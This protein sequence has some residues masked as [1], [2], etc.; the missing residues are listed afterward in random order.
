[1]LPSILPLAGDLGSVRFLLKQLEFNGERAARQQWNL[2]ADGSAGE[3][4]CGTVRV[5]VRWLFS[6]EVEPTEDEEAPLEEQLLPIP[7]ELS[8]TPT[9]RLPNGAS[10]FSPSAAVASLMGAS[11]GIVAAGGIAGQPRAKEGEYTLYVHVIEC[12]EMS[13]R[14][15]DNKLGDLSICV[16]CFGEEFSTK[17]VSDATSGVFDETFFLH[18]ERLTPAALNS[19][20]LLIRAY[21]V[22]TFLRD[23]LIGQNTISLSHIYFKQERRM[24]RRWFALADPKRAD[25]GVQGYV[26][27][28]IQLCGPDDPLLPMDEAAA[29]AE[30]GAEGGGAGAVIRPP[31]LKTSLHFLVVSFRRAKHL[32]RMDRSSDAPDAFCRVSFNNHN[33]Q[34]P[35]ITSRN[36]AWHYQFWLPIMFPAYG[37]RVLI[38]VHDQDAFNTHELIGEFN[39]AFGDDTEPGWRW[40][41]IYNQDSE[42]DAR[43][44]RLW[45]GSLL[46]N[47]EVKNAESLDLPPEP[48]YRELPPL[49][50]SDPPEEPYELRV[51]A[52]AGADLLP[53]KR[54]HVAVSWG[55]YN[56]RTEQAVDSDGESGQCAWLQELTRVDQFLRLTLPNLDADSE[57]PD[58]LI[59]LEE[60]GMGVGGMSYARRALLRISTAELIERS[61]APEWRLFDWVDAKWGRNRPVPKL[62]LSVAAAPSRRHKWE[63]ARVR[64]EAF[65]PQ[66]TLQPRRPL[67]LRLHLYAAR[68]LH[69]QQAGPFDYMPDAYVRLEYLGKSV[70]TPTIDDTMQPSYFR[71]LQLRAD[72]YENLEIAPDVVVSVWDKNLGDDTLLGVVR[73]R[74]AS[75]L[76]HTPDNPAIVQPP[77]NP[78][79]H[80]LYARGSNRLNQSHASTSRPEVL[81]QLE[82][83]PLSTANQ[84]LPPPPSLL[85]KLRPATIEIVALGVRGVQ[86]TA[87]LLPPNKPFMRFS[88]PASYAGT[89]PLAS[90]KR[91]AELPVHKRTV[92][93][94]PS[95]TPSPKSPNFLEVCQL[96]VLIP[97]PWNGL[98]A[99]SVRMELVDEWM[100]GLSEATLGKATLDIASLPCVAQ[101]GGRI[102]SELFECELYSTPVGSWLA[103][104]MSDVA[105]APPNWCNTRY[106]PQ[107]KQGV[108]LLGRGW[109]WE[110]EWECLVETEADDHGFVT[111]AHGW[112]YS[113]SFMN[114]TWTADCTTG[115]VRRRRWKRTQLANREGRRSPGGSSLVL[116]KLLSGGYGEESLASSVSA[117]SD[118]RHMPE[119]QRDRP[120]CQGDLESHLDEAGIVF[121]SFDMMHQGLL[122][123]S[124]VGTFK[125]IVRLLVKDQP[126]W[127]TLPAQLGDLLSPKKYEV[128]LYVLTASNLRPADSSGTSDPYVIVK[129]GDQTKGSRDTHLS[130]V[131]NAEFYSSFL[132]GAD[133]PG[134]SKLRVEVWDHDLFSSDDLIGATE[135]DLE[136]RA[137]SPDWRAFGHRTPVESRPLYGPLSRQPQGMLNM[138]IDIVGANKLGGEVEGEGG[139]S[140][141]KTDVK[142]AKPIQAAA[143]ASGG[144]LDSTAQPT[145]AVA[146][147]PYWDVSP[148]PA[149]DW[150]LRLVVWDTKDVVCQDLNTLDNMNDLY[151]IAQYADGAKQE[152]DTHWR[153][154]GGKAHF[155][156]RMLFPLTLNHNRSPHE[157]LRLQLWDRDVTN[158]DDCA[159]EITIDLRPWLNKCFW[160]RFANAS[161][162]DAPRQ[163]GAVKKEFKRGRA[164]VPK[165]ERYHFSEKDRRRVSTRR[166]A[167]K[168][169]LTGKLGGAVASIHG[170][171]ERPERSGT[172]DLNTRGDKDLEKLVEKIWLPVYMPGSGG[173]ER[174]PQGW[175]NISM[176]L[177]D[178][179]LAKNDPVGRGREAPNKQPFLGPPLGRV[180]LSLN[181]F[182]M[183]YQLLGPKL[184]MRVAVPMCCACCC[185]L[186]I[187]FAPVLIQLSAVSQYLED[188]GIAV[189]EPA[190][191]S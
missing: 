102:T 189:E 92:S 93:V 41:Q 106:E 100:G 38:S 78:V 161:A 144:S 69:T 141:V 14:D 39:L 162:A 25:Q 5:D 1:M 91:T 48:L 67:E 21:D 171:I 176:E 101:F 10:A 13:G 58:V 143:V 11:Q 125:G 119:W 175:V 90:Q 128:R 129:L 164:Q 72:A 183:M 24:L 68:G 36:P 154:K 140:G 108:R 59:Y 28:S 188:S 112:E 110:G 95:C 120:L 22:N 114:G 55:E 49:P 42:L 52:Y 124:K 99:P 82:V 86:N 43:E 180:K 7:S 184:C 137:F 111:D 85:P 66:L 187:I 40:L 44:P 105:N 23:A 155:N 139:G 79:W 134:C 159:G 83:V 121:S 103:P 107:S 179:T 94:S 80:P 173:E 6:D 131:V 45:R 135:I 64:M 33:V 145:A 89:P 166:R 153:S 71:T 8:F 191:T 118:P 30:G 163:V 16:S 76:L 181:P 2:T 160:E 26:L 172:W 158:F 81:F 74:I 35:V 148:P 117:F 15:L 177:V 190:S 168:R 34:T 151:V 126:S 56:W 96:E 186:L 123:S 146:A 47:L 27:L 152:T 138:F 150:E 29:A 130:G 77:P 3:E 127:T 17:T 50:T 182:S 75:A 174:E 63:Q 142:T 98:L 97:E 87:G 51:I 132:L 185:I 4:V 113:T 32:P 84:T 70:D 167:N 133:L 169:S 73:V 54:W 104:A 18:A 136:E 88:G 165:Q 157:R 20:S 116:Q 46:V 61:L 149:Q 147:C 19:S 156:W 9:P 60:K 12:Q 57:L 170:A 37:A 53:G 31:S 178:A 109:E 65:E 122:S 115:F 62:R